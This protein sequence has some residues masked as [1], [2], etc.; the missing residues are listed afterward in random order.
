ML[1]GSIIVILILC[2]VLGF[3]ILVQK[4]KG[5]GL[6]GSFGTLGAQ[7]MGVQKSGDT[8]EKGTWIIMAAIAA[9]CIASTMFIPKTTTAPTQ[10]QTEQS[11]DQN[12]PSDAPNAQ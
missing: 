7:V 5:S 4:P 12:Q 2:F 9:L 3:F 1:V 10:Q 11:A 6:S 8:F